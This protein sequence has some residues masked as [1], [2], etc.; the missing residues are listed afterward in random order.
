MQKP[1]MGK[2][3]RTLWVFNAWRPVGEY[4]KRWILSFCAPQTRPGPILGT[5]HQIRVQGILLDVADD[6]AET[7]LGFH[8]KTLVAA[9]LQMAITN[10]TAIFL[11]A[12]DVSEYRSDFQLLSPASIMRSAWVRMPE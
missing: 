4:G 8:R 6:L 10:L 3:L 5:S 2:S 11:P 7:A 12:F 1:V 9:L